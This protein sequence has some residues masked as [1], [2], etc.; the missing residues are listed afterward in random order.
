MKVSGVSSI[1]DRKLWDKGIKYLRRRDKK[2]ARIL[3]KKSYHDMKLNSDYYGALVE[4]IVYQQIAGNAAESIMK[5]FKGLYNG[6]IPK[7]SEFLS[8]EENLIKGSGISPQKYSYIKDLSERLEKGLV[9]LERLNSLPDAKVIE[10]LDAVKGIGRWT[11]EM[12]LI[13]SLGR[14]DVLPMDDLG[15]R[16]AVK[17]VYSLKKLPDAKKLAQLSK[18]WHPYCTIATLCLWRSHDV[19][20]QEKK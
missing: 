7:P 5:K 6:R 16:K 4:S 3:T 18:N 12:F 13:F 19:V 9:E 15:I 1:T 11:A 2:L 14:T 8:T 20:T 10:E 17:K